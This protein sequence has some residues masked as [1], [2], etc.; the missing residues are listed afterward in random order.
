MLILSNNYI[1]FEGDSINNIYF[2][3]NGECGFV[4]PKHHNLKYIDMKQGQYFGVID[5]VACCMNE[6]LYQFENFM[7]CKTKL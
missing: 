6:G 1:Y 5:I 2:L 4:L 3:K 7:Q